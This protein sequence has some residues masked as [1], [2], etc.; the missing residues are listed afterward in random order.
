LIRG[1]WISR[2]GRRAVEKGWKTEVDIKEFIEG[3]VYRRVVLDR[4][5][6]GRSDRTDYEVAE[7]IY[8]IY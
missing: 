4:E 3:K 2:D 6:D 8:N 7:E 5:I 1:Y